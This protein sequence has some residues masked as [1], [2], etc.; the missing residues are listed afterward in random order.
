MRANGKWLQSVSLESFRSLRGNVELGAALNIIVGPNTSGKTSLLEAA[1]TS[2][3]LNYTDIRFSNY[4]LLIMHASRGSEKHSIASLVST[5]GAPARACVSLGSEESCVEVAKGAR[6]ESR[7][8]Q[9]VPVVDVVL[10]A[11]RRKCDLI[12]TLTPTDI[13]IKA[14]G[15]DCFSQELGVGV[16]TPGIMPYNFFDR[17]IGRLKREQGSL[18]ALTL[19][20]AGRKFWVDLASDDWDQM[21]AYVIEDTGQGK[22]RM[23]IFYSV[24]RGLQRGLQYLLQLSFADI[25]LVDEV[26]S[27]MHPELLETI[28]AKTAE[29]A[30]K[31]KQF[32]ITTQSLEAA[33][34]LAAA[35]IARDRAAWRSPARLLEET[36][37]ACAKPDNEDE[38]ERLLALVV[39]NRDGDSLRSMKL[40]G[41][42]ALSHIAGSRDVRL[43]YTLL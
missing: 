13:A 22:S 6:Q 42:G 10:K 29:A 37:R 40:A 21:A 7:G 34:M 1:A 26:E 12:Y 9:I 8:H 28:A 4:Y 39:L 38:M 41:C 35:L 33:R 3:I 5:E 19:E 23:V 25:I 27:A 2:L 14:N 15:E 17:L 20:M 16:L 32:V 31:G 18:E 30:R 24:G 11:T 43:S 36:R